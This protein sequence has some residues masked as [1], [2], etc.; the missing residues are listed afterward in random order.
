MAK[1]VVTYIDVETF[2]REAKHTMSLY[3]TPDIGMLRTILC[4]FV[5]AV[6]TSPTGCLE[7]DVLCTALRCLE[8]LEIMA[9]E[10]KE[11]ASHGVGSQPHSQLFS[12]LSELVRPPLLSDDEEESL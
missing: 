9:E 7:R 6:E 5:N 4:Q 10:Q 11:A 8:R 12:D 1:E 3:S 2:A